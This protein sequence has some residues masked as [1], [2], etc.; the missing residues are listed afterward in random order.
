MRAFGRRARVC[1]TSCACGRLAQ[2]LAQVLY[3]HKAGGSNPS[4]PTNREHGPKTSVFGPFHRPRYAR[5]QTRG[6]LHVTQQA[7]RHL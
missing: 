6:R 3:T 7:H 1:Y 5:T 2:W 4:S